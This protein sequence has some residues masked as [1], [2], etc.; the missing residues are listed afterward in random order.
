MDAS[1]LQLTFWHWLAL[2][3]IL[4]M[5]EMAGTGGYL[6]W[7]GLAAGFTALCLWLLP[8]LSWH[9]QVVIFAISSVVSAIGWWKY[10]HLHP[11]NVDEPLL[12]QR[13]SQYVG[14]L[15]TLTDAT[16]NGRG[17]IRI[18]DSFW[19]VACQQDLP[20]GTPVRV[21]SVE[22]DQILRIETQ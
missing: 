14:R 5:L 22:H 1:L 2:C 13:S 9:W 11:K 19:E 15:F 8:D 7:A 21:T 20:A 17:R 18:D 4:L 16:E 12:N 6:L 10:Q 3:L